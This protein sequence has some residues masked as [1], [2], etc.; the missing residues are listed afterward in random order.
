MILAPGSQ[1]RGGVWPLLLV[2]LILAGSLCDRA[3][4]QA[5]EDRNALRQKALEAARMQAIVLGHISL[6]RDVDYLHAEFESLIFPA[7]AETARQELVSSL[8]VEIGKVNRC[9]D[10]GPEQVEKL[11]LLGRGDIR[12]Y[13]ARFEASKDAFVNAIQRDEDQDRILENITPLKQTFQSGL[14]DEASLFYRG[15][16]KILTASQAAQLEKSVRERLHARHLVDAEVACTWIGRG[17]GI[18]YAQRE[19]L[20][21]FL[22]RE[23]VPARR[24]GLA[25]TQYL[26]WQLARLP[27]EKLRPLF[28]ANQFPDL[29]AYL[30]KFQDFKPEPRQT[31]KTFE[32]NDGTD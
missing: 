9:C 15:L 27:R 1:A 20:L 16:P 8:T 3:Y 10:L 13:F 22:L 12:R 4:G 11:N 18:S 17:I 2:A 31:G 30:A 21:E 25:D 19:K 14:F 28:N 5:G 23:T 32:D 6:R 29:L 26:L 24:K 7:D